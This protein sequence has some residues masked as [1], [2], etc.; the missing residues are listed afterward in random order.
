MRQISR[1]RV[2]TAERRDLRVAEGIMTG[3][4]LS[5]ILW[6]LAVLLLH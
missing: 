4:I 5:V 3:S 2:A 6:T 1:S